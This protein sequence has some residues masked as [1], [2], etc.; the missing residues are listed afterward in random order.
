MEITV[1]Y[2]VTYSFLSPCCLTDP[3]AYPHP[4][5]PRAC[6]ASW[7]RSVTT[8]FLWQ[9]LPPDSLTIWNNNKAHTLTHIRPYW[10]PSQP[11]S[12]FL[13]RGILV[14]LRVAVCLVTVLTLPRSLSLG[15]PC[16]TWLSH[17]QK[18][19]G[20]FREGFCFP[21]TIPSLHWNTDGIMEINFHLAKELWLAFS[22][23]Q[24]NAKFINDT[25]S[26]PYL[27][28]T[29][30]LTKQQGSAMTGL[31]CRWPCKFPPFHT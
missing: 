13:A 4:K 20:D 17:K 31:C 18:P 21:Y 15:Y 7:D 11:F 26:Q 30:V 22:Q 16:D 14:L 23:M 12:Y 10:V 24:F 27:P 1:K 5:A 8:V 6:P 9:H 25:P 29:H 19:T 28:R 3:S 2:L